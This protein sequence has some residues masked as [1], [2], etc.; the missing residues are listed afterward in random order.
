MPATESNRIIIVLEDTRYDIN[1]RTLSAVDA[2]DF[3]KAVGRSLSQAFADGSVDIDIIAGLVW[4]V[5]RKRRKDLAYAKVAKGI[6]YATKIDMF[7]PDDP[8]TDEDE[9]PPAE[10]EDT[11]DPEV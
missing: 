6:N 5:E 4:L 2:Q 1:M 8:D 10:V 7:D 11:N 9:L 3:R